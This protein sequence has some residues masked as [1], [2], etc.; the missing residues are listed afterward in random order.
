MKASSGKKSKT[1]SN[2]LQ[3]PEE[4]AYKKPER[5][6]RKNVQ[7]SSCVKTIEKPT[8][9]KTPRKTT[10]RKKGSKSK[11]QSSEAVTANTITDGEEVIENIVVKAPLQLSGPMMLAH[12]SPKSLEQQL[13][14]QPE[15]DLPM[16]VQELSP[17]KSYHDPPISQYSTNS[18]MSPTDNQALTLSTNYV[19]Y[20]QRIVCED[21]TYDIKIEPKIEFPL[22]DIK[23]KTQKTQESDDESQKLYNAF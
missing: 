3:Q 13:C 14:Q 11:E 5:E 12:V 8:K 10:P 19:D 20:S 16:S 1:K 23:L 17:K 4:Y 6:K 7:I 2:F 18:L 22:I 9:A 15:S 21:Q